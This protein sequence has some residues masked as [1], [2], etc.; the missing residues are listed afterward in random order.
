[1]TQ[2]GVAVEIS[3]C[4]QETLVEMTLNKFSRNDTEV[5]IVGVVQNIVVFI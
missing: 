1:M 3:P 5:K 4:G 2:L